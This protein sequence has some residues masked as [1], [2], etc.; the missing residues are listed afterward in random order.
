MK[1]T[2]SLVFQ[3]SFLKII[4]IINFSHFEKKDFLKNSKLMAI[5]ILNQ[6]IMKLINSYNQ[7]FEFY[8]SYQKQNNK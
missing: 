6:K 8:F 3:V 7:L 2:L 1:D 4:Q 5:L